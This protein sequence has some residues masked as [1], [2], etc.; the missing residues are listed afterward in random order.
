LQHA[1]KLEPRSAPAYYQL[2]RAL[3]SSGRSEEAMRAFAAAREI[4]EADRARAA[5]E[6]RGGMN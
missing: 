4:Q 1:V 2:G 5:K 6:L 3:Q